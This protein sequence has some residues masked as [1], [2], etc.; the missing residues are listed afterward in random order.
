[1]KIVCSKKIHGVASILLAILFTVV[2]LVACSTGTP[3]E[4]DGGGQELSDDYLPSDGTW[5][6]LGPVIDPDEVIIAGA[7]TG[8]DSPIEGGGT[9]GMVAGFL[10]SCSV[11]TA[12]DGSLIA[13]YALPDSSGEITGKRQHA[14]QWDDAAG[15]WGS[16]TGTEDLI[17]DFRMTVGNNGSIWTISS[18]AQDFTGKVYNCPE[19]GDCS[20]Y[21]CIDSNFDTW[22]WD[23]GINS[24]ANPVA[25]YT[26]IGDNPDEGWT[27]HSMV[28]NGTWGDHR[29]YTSDYELKHNQYLPE[30]PNMRGT[31]AMAIAPVYTYAA[32]V[33]LIPPEEEEPA[34]QELKVIRLKARDAG[35]SW[36]NF[37]NSAAFADCTSPGYISM[38]ID[39][40]GRPWILVIDEE[41]GDIH[42]YYLGPA[43]VWTSVPVADTSTNPG[44]FY[45]WAD[46]MTGTDIKMVGTTPVISY[47]KIVD[48][49]EHIHGVRVAAYDADAGVWQYLGPEED[50]AVTENEDANTGKPNLAV[51]WE[52]DMPAK[53]YAAFSVGPAMNVIMSSEAE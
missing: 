39:E 19:Y 9:V 30:G 2:F 1:M 49:T 53:F 51:A 46:D 35:A 22:L 36:D 43:L 15:E 42:V 27:V 33:E 5:T 8:G 44:Y 48:E 34:R 29:T 12:S 52:E 38:D 26:T 41:T 50:F 10:S 13:A 37:G 14:Y 20:D 18:L 21:E 23:I 32:F 47:V 28:L 7:P 45:G 4:E 6:D 17:N 16:R 25:I 40:E 31:F 24:T 11:E 3:L